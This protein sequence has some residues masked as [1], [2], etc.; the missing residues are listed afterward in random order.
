[1]EDNV[2]TQNKGSVSVDGGR[3]EFL[4]DDFQKGRETGMRMRDNE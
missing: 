4:G 2:L 1:M 3:E